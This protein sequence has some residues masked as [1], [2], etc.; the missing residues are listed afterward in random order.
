[1]IIPNRITLTGIAVAAVLALLWPASHLEQN[2][3]G[4]PE[5]SH[6]VLDW[7]LDATAPLAA[8]L[9][10]LERARAL[11]DVLLGA[12]FG[13]GML[14]LLLEAGKRLWGRLRISLEPPADAILDPTGLRVGQHL[15]E[16]WEDMFF[17]ESDR[18][19][20]HAAQA[21]VE[22]AD[23][24][25]PAIYD[26]A[27]L[28]AGSQGLDVDGVHY[29]WPDIR[30]VRATVDSLVLPR[31]AMGFGDLKLLA[32]I[33][34]FLGADATVFVLMI[35]AATG[36]LV[37]TARIAL[38]SQHRHNP[39]PFGPFLATAALVWIVFGE[40]MLQWYIRRFL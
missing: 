15:Q 19:R 3:A 29:A 34:A 28:T 25:A 30:C 39:I 6:L 12:A 13:Y 23:N 20:A 31:E 27:R 5:G 36:C 8:K 16:E 22:F 17:R 4:S 7:F 35:A 11:V 1:M 24:T 33:G 10:P 18:C 32:M 26:D 21:T 2:L 40:A 38:R 37:G 9:W 14:W